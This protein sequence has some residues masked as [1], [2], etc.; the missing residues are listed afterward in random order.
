MSA[1]NWQQ[2][3]DTFHEA[4]RLDSGER[5]RFLDKACDGDIE[6]R[7]EVESLLVS[8]NEA[9]N[10]LE[11]PVV[12]ETPR[13]KAGFQLKEGQAISHYRIISPI[14]SG[15]MGEVYLAEDEQLKRSAA[16]K[17]L[18]S[19]LLKSKERLRRFQRE[20][21]VVSALNHPNI[22]TVFE[23]GAEN[24]IKFLASEFVKGETLRARI[25]KGPLT[26]EKSLD[27]AT[28][29]ASALKAAHEAGVVHRDIK[30]ENVMIRDDG[31]VKV[32]DFGLA[33]LTEPPLADS[34]LETQNLLS[35]PGFIMGTVTYM[36]PEQ[37]RARSI[38]ARS[39][40]FS[41]GVVLFEMLSGKVPFTGDTTADVIAE[42]IQTTP[43]PVSRYNDA[44]PDELDRMVAKCLEKERDERYQTSADL[45]ADLKRFSK[46]RDATDK[47]ANVPTASPLTGQITEIQVSPPTEHSVVSNKPLEKRG[48]LIAAAIAAIVIAVLLAAGYWYYSAKNTKQIESIA[49][50]PFVNDGGNA[51]LDYLSDGMTE[52]LI[53]KLSELPNLNVKARASV[54]HYKEK[55]AD[56]KTIG[57]E[58]SVQAVLNGRVVS[59]G[60]NLALFLELV[61]AATGNRLWGEQYNRKQVDL[62]A[63]QND[64][65]LDVSQKLRA[66]LSGA[67]ESKLTK[68]H[69]SDP[70]A[71]QLYLKGRFHLNRLTDDGFYKGRDYFQQ[72]IDKDPNYAM[73]YVGLADSYNML[74]G[75]NAISPN[76][77]Y[78]K[79]KAAAL[80][81]LELDENLAEA[82]T[83]LGTVRFFYEWDWAGAEREFKRAIELNPSYADAH[84][85]YSYLLSAMGR[86]D[87]SRAEM[88]RAQELDP[89]SLVKV[90]GIGEI[91]YYQ[92]HYDQAIAQYQKA[93]EMDPNS[94]F[95]H[96]A[97]GNVF[98]QKGD[99]AEAINHY[100]KSIPLSGDSPDEPATLAY[101][102]A[103]SGNKKEAREILNEL[104]ARSPR[105]YT[106]PATVAF[107]HIG[108]GDKDAAFALL[109]RAVSERDTVLTLLTVEPIFDS[110]R[111]DPRFADLVRRIGLAP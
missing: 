60:D 98:A 47:A 49:V 18:P 53:G 69:T 66:R 101:A 20:A 84:Q 95:A 28:Q 8:L 91:L 36:S 35:R 94:G 102:Y 48:L 85:L 107:V 73:A 103:K 43:P 19:D 21:R 106:S 16:L 100:R 39:D 22:L 90:A 13:P 77:G 56:P 4:L 64:I 52:T 108:L 10:F 88:S 110:L 2:V 74:G 57:K 93:L 79:S 42:I 81:A 9:K 51:D 46:E 41:F 5:D 1:K 80:K 63:M 72:A 67:D 6:F 44:V 71:Y 111:D 96:W 26:L 11:Q 37:A 32:L 87:E 38:D 76:D 55:I 75:W 62:V 99:Y 105:L 23:F 97:I 12:G 61:D 109:D 82:H 45:L 104:E 86:F 70:E 68:R 59:R 65:A 30:P 27:I 92:R 31:Y 78:P 25:E 24:D 40:L 34:S 15:G 17:V 33:K 29:I 7:I 50:M 89:L 83:S 54:F 14:A 58:L 3:K